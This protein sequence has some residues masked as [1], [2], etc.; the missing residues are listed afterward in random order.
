M[1]LRPAGVWNAS[2]STSLILNP[3]GGPA[4]R[5]AASTSFNSMMQAGNAAG[6]SAILRASGLRLAMK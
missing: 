1:C 5:I 3:G 4:A 2:R 6:Q